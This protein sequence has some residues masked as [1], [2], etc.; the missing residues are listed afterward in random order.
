MESTSGDVDAEAA[1]K[2]RRR[3]KW[4]TPAPTPSAVD[5]GAVSNSIPS[6]D[7][8]LGQTVIKPPLP[9][10]LPA[11]AQTMISRMSPMI[12][13]QIPIMPIANAA[14]VPAVSKLD[15]RIYVG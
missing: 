3:S 1:A 4:D 12:P 13:L 10:G 9:I 6:L 14:V 8:P 11:P 15:C 5:T 7:T 2:K